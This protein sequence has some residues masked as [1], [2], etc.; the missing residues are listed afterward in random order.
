MWQVNCLYKDTA[1]G[2]LRSKPSDSDDERNTL[3]YY[4]LLIDAQTGEA[5]KRN[6]EKDRCEY[7]G[8]ISWEDVP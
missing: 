8:F 4:Q 3:D 2:K 1:T 5:V 7:K 6:N